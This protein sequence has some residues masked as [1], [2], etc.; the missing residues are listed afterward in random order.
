MFKHTNCNCTASSVGGNT[1]VLQSG[2][3]VWMWLTQKTDTSLF[4][5]F[6]GIQK[7]KTGGRKLYRSGGGERLKLKKEGEEESSAPSTWARNTMTEEKDDDE[8]IVSSFNRMS[9]WSVKRISK[10]STRE[11]Q[12][13]HRRQLTR[14]PLCMSK[15]SAPFVQ[16]Q[17]TVQTTRNNKHTYKYTEE[18]DRRRWISQH[19]STT[20]TWDTTLKLPHDENAY[21]TPVQQNPIKTHTQTRL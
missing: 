5:V 14:V 6:G 10:H 1:W 19:W 18:S 15:M 12:E 3:K 4:L 2:R 20:Q 9:M 17:H 11:V 8:Y 13:N 7:Q 21:Y 16:Q